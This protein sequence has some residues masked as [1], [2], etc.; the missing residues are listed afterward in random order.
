MQASLVLRVSGKRRD[1]EDLVEVIEG[2]PGRRMAQ[3]KEADSHA[4]AVREDGEK[5][6]H[7]GGFVGAGR[8]MGGQT[9]K[10]RVLR[11]LAW[12]SNSSPAG[13]MANSKR[14]SLTL[15]ETSTSDQPSALDRPL[16]VNADEDEPARIEV[17][18]KPKQVFVKTVPP[19]IGRTELE[20]FFGKVKGFEYLAL[21]EP[22]VK[23]QF[24]RVAWAQFAEGV[25]VGEVVGKLDGQKVG[26]LLSSFPS[27]W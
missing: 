12:A 24:H 15:P 10:K 27:K 3:A 19:T 4:R 25:D 23:K 1:A 18:P 26:T 20:A 9:R 5:G 2:V 13:H 14:S 22:S 17:P 21:T 11:L 8:N 16:D 6:E 7:R